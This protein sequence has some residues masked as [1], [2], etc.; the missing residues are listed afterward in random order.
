MGWEKK[1]RVVVLR[2]RVAKDVV[3][4]TED[5]ETGQIEIDFAETN[6][7]TQL[8]E[9][10]V[11]V[12]TLDDEIM[13][14]AQHYRD[15]ADCENV[16]DELKNQWGWGGFTTHDLKRCQ[17]MARVVA[18][19][20]NWWNIFVRLAEPDKHLEA[21]TSRP[22]LLHAVGKQTSHAGQKIISISSMH[23]KIGKVH[24][25]LERIVAFFKSLKAL[26]EQLTTEQLWY[27]ILSEA[28]K[29]YLKGETLRPPICLLASL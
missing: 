11:L 25:L 1:R 24:K 19:V 8:Y 3:A 20:Y 21:V 7:Q 2:K 6:K 28:V 22:L 13:T 23:G 27:R 26:A 12:T 9:Y 17:L 16:F 10:A 29:K 14:I 18:L 15:R 5:L 4:R